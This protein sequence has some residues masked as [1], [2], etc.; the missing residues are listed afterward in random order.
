MR[1]I[2]RNPYFYRCLDG[3]D[4]SSRA[5]GLGDRGRAYRLSRTTKRGA[6]DDVLAV[7]AAARALLANPFITGETLHVDG[8]A[9]WA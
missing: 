6:F 5:V 7:S 1:K 8:G 9:R 2:Y 4:G 3:K